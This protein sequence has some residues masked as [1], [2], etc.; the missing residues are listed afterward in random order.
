M[1]VE[2]LHSEGFSGD[3]L[4]SHELIVKRGKRTFVPEANGKWVYVSGYTEHASQIEKHTT[5]KW[6]NKVLELGHRV[7]RWTCDGCVSWF[8]FMEEKNDAV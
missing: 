2:T 8:V 7:G 6:A 3:R 1:P 5:H 4:S